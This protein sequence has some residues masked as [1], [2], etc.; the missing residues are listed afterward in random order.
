V[1]K[2]F[3]A[4]AVVAAAEA[5]R[6]PARMLTVAPPVAVAAETA[7][8]AVAALAPLAVALELHLPAM[9]G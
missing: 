7:V 6:H 1:Q 5:Q 8:A 3:P 4:A 9:P 2:T